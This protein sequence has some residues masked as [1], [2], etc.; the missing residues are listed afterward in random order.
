[1]AIRRRL[2]EQLAA[3]KIQNM[4]KKDSEGNWEQ[5]TY[6]II[7]AEKMR[8]FLDLINI[9]GTSLPCEQQSVDGIED[10][11]LKYKTFANWAKDKKISLDGERKGFEYLFR[12]I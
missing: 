8:I 11:L 6:K 7:N 1:M 12:S 5:L 9:T 3:R 10:E 2:M 4:A